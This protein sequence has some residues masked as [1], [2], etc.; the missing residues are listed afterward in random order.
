MAKT[1]VIGDIHGCLKALDAIL[2]AVNP[3]QDDTLVTVGDY[4]D[5]GPDS[6]GVIERLIELQQRTH[7]V[8]LLGNHEEMMLNSLDGKTAPYS[9]FNHG[10]VQ[11]L[12]SYG[13]NGDLKVVPPSH[14]DFLRGLVSYYE[15]ATHF[16][17]HANYD[18]TLLLRE[19]P[20]DLLRWTKL[21]ESMPGPHKSGKTA[22]VGHTHDRAGKVFRSPY[23][24]CVDTYCYGG[25]WLT[26]IDLESDAV[27][28]ATR[29]GELI[30]SP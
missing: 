11:T 29:E 30:S 15:T 9:W 23:L 7:L 6:K 21:T 20:G 27:W 14:L 16:I 28:Q 10:G 26:A 22:V 17:V 12:E 13:F 25:R 1:I 24:I 4:V 3:Q 18:P 5:R 2:N 19:Q 8:P